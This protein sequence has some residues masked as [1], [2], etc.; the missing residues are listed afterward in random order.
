[1][2]IDEAISWYETKLT[3]NRAVG[4]LG[5]Q[6]D[7]AILAI[8]AL[9]EKAARENPEPLTLEELR[10]MVRKPVWVQDLLI[11]GC[12]AWHFVME[13]DGEV[14][15]FDAVALAR[16]IVGYNATTGENYGKTWLAYRHKPDIFGRTYEAV[17]AEAKAR[18][19]FDRIAADKREMAFYIMCPHGKSAPDAECAG[20]SCMDCSTGW[21]G[22]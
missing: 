11:S 3:V 21:T 5:S 4:F 9:R 17:N 12:S 13:H 22:L 2:T 8:E 16:R 7:A 19:N 15:L 14:R 6:N 18:T 20:K 1:M 10:K